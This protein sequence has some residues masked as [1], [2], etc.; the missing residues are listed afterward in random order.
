MRPRAIV[1][2]IRLHN[3]NEVGGKNSIARAA[4]SET[5]PKD[6]ALQSL[7]N[8]RR[9]QLFLRQSFTTPGVYL[10]TALF[11]L[12]DQAADSSPEW[13]TGSVAMP[14]GPLRVMDNL[15]HRTPWQAW[16]KACL[17]MSLAAIV[18][19]ARGLGR[20]RRMPLSVIS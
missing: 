17:A 15:S 16:A 10:K 2:C 9:F 11:S 5:V 7:S 3:S 8:H 20:V 14:N 6:V 12:S 18:V 19:S 4:A 13:A 1:Q